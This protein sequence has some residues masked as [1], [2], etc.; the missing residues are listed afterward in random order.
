MVPESPT[1]S[2]IDPPATTAGITIPGALLD[3]AGAG[4][5]LTGE[6]GTGKSDAVLGLLDRGHHLIAD[7]A[8]ELY[9]DSARLCGRCPPELYGLV[10]VRGIGAFDVRSVFGDNSL[11][12]AIEIDL[13][14][15]LERGPPAAD[16]LAVA[17][18]DRIIMGA[19]IPQLRLSAA[20]RNLPL[21]LETA[22]KV[23]AAAGRRRSTVAKSHKVNASGERDA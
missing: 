18:S 2:S 4:V 6:S 20:G 7:D 14:I 22:V 5:L 10:A 9:R 19:T 8:V 11:C 21:L 1:A 15:V 17:R 12:Q 23:H 13:E 16:G 3:I